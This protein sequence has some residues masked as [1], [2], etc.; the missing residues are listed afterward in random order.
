[1][2]IKRELNTIVDKHS[3]NPYKI[4]T[5]EYETKWRVIGEVGYTKEVLASERRKKY[6]IDGKVYGGFWKW[7]DKLPEANKSFKGLRSYIAE[8]G[9]VPD[10]EDIEAAKGIKNALKNNRYLQRIKQRKEIKK[11]LSDLNSNI[12]NYIETYSKIKENNP[13]NSLLNNKDNL[14]HKTE[15]VAAS[16]NA[17]R[18]GLEKVA[19]FA[20]TALLTASLI[21]G[22]VGYY[23]LDRS[24]KD[25]IAKL[26]SQKQ[27][28]Y[29]EKD[30]QTSEQKKVESVITTAKPSLE[31]KLVEA[32]AESKKTEDKEI[33]GNRGNNYHKDIPEYSP[34][35]LKKKQERDKR[36]APIT[37]RVKR[38]LNQLGDGV[39]KVVSSPFK[40]AY[41]VL[42]IH[43]KEA[44]KNVIDMPIG[45]IETVGG[46][47]GAANGIGEGI[48]RGLAYTITE[49]DSLDNG[50]GHLFDA[51]IGGDFNKD[52]HSDFVKFWEW[53]QR[54]GFL[55]DIE[56]HPYKSSIAI[57]EDAFLIWLS[58]NAGH[59]GKGGGAEISPGR[60]GGAG[61]GIPGRG[62]GAGS[63]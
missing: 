40:F 61:G 52:F 22:C 5:I 9:Y 25:E 62:G 39:W 55:S 44:A 59:G 19:I 20:T 6:V 50:L 24:A 23:I 54:Y 56:N 7:I 58:S 42:T 28:V 15:G 57:I 36:H 32:K 27:I 2:G 10:K 29:V 4:G 8:S 48:T 18:G 17:K 16:Q 13:G 63:Q 51:S 60:S 43:T 21:G 37:A 45:A 47:L 30:K 31:E 46:G 1:M 33:W 12:N 11:A 35:R 49:N 53:G 14:E 38:N 34:E 26:K 3:V 41:N